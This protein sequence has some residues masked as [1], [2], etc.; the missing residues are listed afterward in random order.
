MKDEDPVTIGSLKAILSELLDKKLDEK[1][2]LVYE[3]REENKV[4]R[5]RIE[6]IETRVE[7]S[8][9]YSRRNNIVIYGIP[10]KQDENVIETAVAACEAVEVK[11]ES[12]EIDAAH[13]LPQRNK[14][15]SP[16]FILRLVSRFK[17]E[18]IMSKANEIKPTADKMGGDSKKR[19]FYNEHLSARN[20]QIII[21]AKRIW[22]EYVVWSRNGLVY[23]RSKE[24]GSKRFRIYSID[25][26]DQLEANMKKTTQTTQTPNKAGGSK[27]TIQDRSPNDTDSNQSTKKWQS[28]LAKYR[29]RK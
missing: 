16:P 1:F 27:R 8:E 2:Q 19:L 24:M 13:R 12:H 26:I 14:T 6:Q 11:I 15:S 25:E 20:Q 9:N 29:N 5:D 3:I 28:Q 21:S 18:E 4:I 7:D 22:D 23:G 10:E 17:K